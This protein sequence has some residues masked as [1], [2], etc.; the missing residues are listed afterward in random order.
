VK[1]VQGSAKVIFAF[2]ITG[3]A[4]WNII[5][6][7][8]V[9]KKIKRHCQ[10]PHQKNKQSFLKVGSHVIAKV[11]LFCFCFVSLVA[12]RRKH[13]SPFR[14]PVDVFLS[15]YMAIFCKTFVTKVEL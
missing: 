11:L 15:C 2:F 5:G 12:F 9:K 1:L 8:K 3:A 13:K 6:N 7:K 10:L 14:R 4:H